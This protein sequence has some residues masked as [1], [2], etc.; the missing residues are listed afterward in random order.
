M[1]AL[2]PE[3]L[4][5]FPLLKIQDINLILRGFFVTPNTV[6]YFTTVD[7]FIEQNIP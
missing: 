2:T 1:T 4:V 5:E 3:H 7:F 6:R